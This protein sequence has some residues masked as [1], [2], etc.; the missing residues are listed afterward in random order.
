LAV[1]ISSIIKYEDFKAQGFAAFHWRYDLEDWA[2]GRW[3]EKLKKKLV[4]IRKNPKVLVNFIQQTL[5]QR[6]I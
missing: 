5:E 1:Q 4:G 2:D 3:D 6:K